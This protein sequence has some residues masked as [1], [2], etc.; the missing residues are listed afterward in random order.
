MKKIAPS[1]L[2]K[3]ALATLLS[4]VDDEKADG[5]DM[6]SR[7]VK[8]AVE[9]ILQE[10]LEAEQTETLG[11]ERYARGDG[12]GVYRNGY[13]PGHLKTAEGVVEVSRPQIRGLGEPYR[14]QLWE[15]LQSLSGQ[16][17]DLITE[18]Y[19]CGMSTRDVEEALERALGGFVLS[20]SSVSEITDQLIEEY[21]KFKQR[22]LS[23]FEVA[24]LFIDAVYEPLRRYG[25]KTG[26]TCCW[27]YLENGARVLLDL[28]T[29]N[30]ESGE[31]C[32]AFL[33]GMV[34]RGLRAPLTVTTDG[35]PGLIQAVEK[36]WPLSKRVRCWYHKMQN[37]KAKVPEGAQ[38][39]WSAFKKAVV[40]IRDAD[41]VAEGRRRQEEALAQYE[42]QF[43]EACQCLRE[44]REASLNHLHVAPRHRKYV[45]TT[46]LVERTFVEQR[47]RTKTIPHVWDEGAL[48]KLVFGTLLRVS[49]RWARAQFGALEQQQ[50]RTL[51]HAIL[52]EPDLAEEPVEPK[53][54][55][56]SPHR[57]A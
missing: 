56:R 51:R 22:D 27:A 15:R 10:L 45:R 18:M 20:K 19:V 23:G 54:T 4:G 3:Q 35:S 9:S 37:L 53:R 39:G 57:V 29:M 41:S 21:E 8:L 24:Y 5:G 7:L 42:K 50:I 16:L 44:D 13:E 33:R 48:V 6:L 14:S 2:K 49:D 52:G 43:P 30:A 38:P 47:R 28:T 17:R 11:R 32:L 46:N 36:M 26:V 12:A 25:S 40:K 1:Q 55:R 31:A 34:E